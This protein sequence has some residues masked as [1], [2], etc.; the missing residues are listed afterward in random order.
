MLG[1]GFIP[2]AILLVGLFYLPESPRWLVKQG[3]SSEAATVLRRMGRAQPEAE[4]QEIE[5][6]EAQQVKRSLG[7]ALRELTGPGL[8]LALIGALGVSVLTQLMG[9][10]SII[11]YAPTTLIAVGFGQT[12]SIVASVGIG[13]LNVVVTVIALYMIDRIGRKRLLLLGCVGMVIAMLILGIT[14]LV[15]PH[16]SSIVA[17]VTLICLFLFIISFG[18]SWG[19]CVRVVIS[20]LLPLNVRGTAMGLVLVL[21]WLAN[22]LVGLIFPI[23]LASAGISIVFLTFA[24]VGIISFFFVLGLIP[25]TKGKSLEKIEADLRRQSQLSAVSMSQK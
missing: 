7:A 16:G 23:A 17:S 5:N 4:L 21:N 15:S 9:I 24:V 2:S 3:R 12:A 13:A 14:T 10:N 18:M 25:E 20:E 22:F 6:T 11:Y 1:L 8:R 19:V